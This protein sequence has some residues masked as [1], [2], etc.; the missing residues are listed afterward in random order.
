MT[1]DP[2]RASAG[3]KDP[4]SWN[5]YSYVGGDPVNRIDRRGLYWEVVGY[6][7]VII[8]YDDYE[9]QP[10]YD[11][12]PRIEWVDDDDPGAEPQPTDGG[13]ELT[14]VELARRNMAK[15]APVALG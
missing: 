6:D 8:G 9:G 1:P 14:P 12:I 7:E 13:S 5:R 11:W 10:I 3:R 15:A 4:Q 2:Y